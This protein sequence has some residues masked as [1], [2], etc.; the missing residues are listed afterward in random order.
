MWALF[1]KTPGCN[2]KILSCITNLF[3]RVST[4]LNFNGC[5]FLYLIQVMFLTQMLYS[6]VGHVFS[7][8]FFF[9]ALISLINKIYFTLQ[10]FLFTYFLNFCRKWFM[11]TIYCVYFLLDMPIVCTSLLNNYIIKTSKQTCLLILVNWVNC[12]MFRLEE[13]CP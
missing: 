6:Y 13:K 9:K 1:E 3:E 8:A 11:K 5:L 4:Y 7:F 12:D 2:D 10:D